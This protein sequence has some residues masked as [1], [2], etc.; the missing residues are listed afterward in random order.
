MNQ[1]NKPPAVWWRVLLIFGFLYLFLLGIQSMGGAFKW[2]GKDYTKT[3]LGS[4]TGPLVS[5]F[6]GIFATTL[7]QSSSTITSMIVTLV[8]AGQLPYDSA[9]FMVMGANVGTTVT[10]SLV[11][12]GHMRHSAEYERAFAAATVHDFFNVIVLA[13][14]FPLEVAFR[15]LDKM[16]GWAA[17]SFQDIGGTK[18]ASPIKAITKPVVNG[19]KDVC[20]S[21]SN[22]LNDMFGTDF[23]GAGGGLLLLIGILMTFAG[24]IFLVKTLKGVMISKLENLFD[25]VIFRSPVRGLVFGFALTVLVQSSSISTSVAVPLVGAGI[26]TIHQVMPYTMGANIG[27][28][29]TALIASLAAM[30][31]VDLGD[32]A[33]ARQAFLGLELAF[34]HVLFNL[35]GVAIVW[36]FRKL[37]IAIAERFARI[38]MRNKMIPL[39]YIVLTFYVVPFLII[40]LSR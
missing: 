36:W 23:F 8:A 21:I 14:L 4:G 39:L 12:L 32:A 16:A 2:L 25:R 33:G 35:M 7:V 30:A 27:T 38:A 17:H 10:N 29:I 24:L 11:S 15:F 3:L 6:V 22:G 26:L 19:L 13:I 28:T 40:I 31:A 34:H 37:P 20:A 5:L 18:A 9:I 1:P